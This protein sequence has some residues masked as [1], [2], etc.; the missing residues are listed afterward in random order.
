MTGQPAPTS[1]ELRAAAWRIVAAESGPITARVL[2]KRA[3]LTTGGAARFLT[4]WTTTGWLRRDPPPGAVAP[5]DMP[6]TRTGRTGTPPPPPAPARPARTTP[7]AS[8]GHSRPTA[9]PARRPAGATAGDPRLSAALALAETGRA[10][11][12]L[13]RSKRPV[14]NCE[15][16]RTAPAGHD[17]AGCDC[18]TCHGFYA[19]STDP[20]RIRAM[21]AAVPTGLLAV[22]TGAASNLLV[23]DIDPRHGGTIDKTVM[24]VTATVATGGGGWHLHYAHPGGTIPSRPLPGRAG[25]DIK[26][27]GGLAVVPPSTHPDT[28]RPYQWVG[29]HP[30][31]EM[32]P[33]LLT[34]CQ[35]PTSPPPRTPANTLRTAVDPRNRGGGISHPDRLLSAHLNAVT[36][37]VEGRRRTTLYG[38]ARGVARLIAAG[39]LDPTAGYDALTHAGRAA[40]QSD[41]D[42]HAATVG[43]FT[44]EGLAL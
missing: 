14:A 13:G 34:L 37:A 43:G 3:E 36:R 21:L 2:A 6:Y 18:L 4:D 31:N 20:G 7:A 30:V 10:V 5:Y 25:V 16:C 44:A 29:N 22:R 9:P 8:S 27:D 15:T 33:A 12:V 32:P 40:E 1:T 23:V 38:A 19:A 17:P 39:H 35:T 28:G 24:T 41:R 11:F 26:A 42:I